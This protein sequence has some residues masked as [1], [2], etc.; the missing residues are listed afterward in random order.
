M[1]D[2]LH[3][4]A[5]HQRFAAPA[6]DLAE[7]IV[8]QREAA[9]D[10]HLG[11]AGGG[12]ADER[13]KLRLA[14]AQR[15]FGGLGLG[16]VMRDADKADMAPLRIPAR[17]RGGVEPAPRAMDVAIAPLELEGA[18]ARLAGDRL[19]KD[20]R[21][22]VRVDDPPPVEIERLIIGD[23]EERDIGAIDEAAP[24]IQP[25][26]P[27]GDGGAVRDH[28]ELVLAHRKRLGRRVGHRGSMESI[29]NFLA[30]RQG[31]ST[32]AT[33]AS[34]APPVRASGAACRASR[35]PGRSC[36]RP[37]TPRRPRRSV[38]RARSPRGRARRRG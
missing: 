20:V 13:G 24:A 25:S 1:R 14:L 27:Y 29:S 11:K 10:V 7:A 21:G 32:F 9:L 34:P 31:K 6:G 36:P 2:L 30:L 19:C 15:E 4:H 5:A 17:L 12:L 8:D 16:H 37:A 28:A 18:E 38:R 23:A 22:V 35:R 33:G 3:R 26:H